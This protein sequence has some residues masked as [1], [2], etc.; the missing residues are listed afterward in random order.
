[1]ATDAEVQGLRETVDHL[2]EQLHESA[3]AQAQLMAEDRGW[4]RLTADHKGTMTQTQRRDLSLQCRAMNAVNPLVKRG[5]TVRAGY[6]WG[7]GLGLSMEDESL[8]DIVQS[9]LDDDEVRGILTGHQAHLDLETRIAVDGNVF[10]A[11]FT[12]PMTGR[13][14]PRVLDFHEVEDRFTNPQDK[15]EPWFYKRTYSVVDRPGATARE[16]TVWHPDLR[17]RP[18]VRRRH[19]DDKRTQEILWDAPVLHVHDN[20][21]PGDGWGVPDVFAAL[22]WA[23][24]YT[25]FLTDWANLT[26]ALSRIAWRLSGDRKSSAGQMRAALEATQHGVAGGSMAVTGGGTLEAVPK[27]GATIDAES[28]RPMAALVASALGVPVT[29]LLADP[30]QTGARAVAETLD[31]PTILEMNGRRELWREAFR[32]IL[33][34][35]IDQAAL[36]PLSDSDLRGRAVRD[37]D[38]LTVDL[39]AGYDRAIDFDWPS[40]EDDATTDVVRAVVEATSTGLVP[41]DTAMRLLLRALKVRDVDRI[42][43]EWTDEHGR[44]LDP[45]DPDGPAAGMRADTGQEGQEDYQ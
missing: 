24:A 5:V 3:A 20:G 38:R 45:A 27:T 10:I 40:L 26:K 7:Q 16:V 43:E 34:H 31:K 22:P 6:V 13:V 23:R 30:G 11:L 12:D 4:Q 17:Y 35:V 32:A 21:D 15:N 37:G 18:Q 19:M 9:F 29:T 33:N 28:G 14:R 25:S 1:M 39:G 8:N 42:I 2:Q 41:D 36:A 44:F